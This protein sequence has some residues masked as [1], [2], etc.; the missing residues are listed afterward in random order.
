MGATG[1]SFASTTLLCSRKG[2]PDAGARKGKERED[3]AKHHSF[4]IQ[5]VWGLATFSSHKHI[6]FHACQ[7]GEP[8]VSQHQ[9]WC[10][11]TW[12]FG[13]AWSCLRKQQ[14]LS[15]KCSQDCV[16]VLQSSSR[17]KW[18]LLECLL[19]GNSSSDPISHS[20]NRLWETNIQ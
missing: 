3:L 9:S 12:L 10:K 19:E 16:S 4:Q 13:R 18:Y 5:L 2:L 1:V 6:S 11:P 7:G 15:V 8:G 14:F 17:S 20:W